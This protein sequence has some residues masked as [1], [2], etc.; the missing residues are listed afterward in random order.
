MVP[1]P[2]R[3]E[4]VK[5]PEDNKRGEEV[6]PLPT[7][8][9]RELLRGV[10]MSTCLSGAAKH[11]ADNDAGRNAQLKEDYGLSRQASRLDHFLSH[12]WRTSRWKKYL[13]MLVMFNLLPAA[14][15]SSIVS[16]I[17]AIIACFTVGKHQLWTASFG[18]VTFLITLFQWQWM[19]EYF[20]KPT[21]VFLDK[22]CIAQHD[23]SLK[24]KGISGLASF[25][26]NSQSLT[27]FW[28]QRYFTRLW[29]TYE[30][31]T[32]FKDDQ[33][34]RL[35]LMPVA[36]SVQIL[37]QAAMAHPLTW[38]YKILVFLI[39][40]VFSHLETIIIVSSVLL[41][42]FTVLATLQ[43]YVTIGLLDDI[44]ALPQQLSNFSITASECY[45][46]SVHHVHPET[47]DEIPCDRRVVFRTL[48]D[49]YGTEDKEDHLA[50]FDH[51]VKTRLKSIVL[52]Q[53]GGGALPLRYSLPVVLSATMPLLPLYLPEWA[54]GQPEYIDLHQFTFQIRELVEFFK[55]GLLVMLVSSLGTHA[56]Y[57]G[58]R[59]KP[60]LS[61]L[62]AAMLLA[63]A[64][65]FS[66]LIF[67]L[68]IEVAFLL[69]LK[70]SLMVLIPFS[71]NLL[72][73]LLLLFPPACCCCK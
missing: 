50:A 9:D 41:P 20:M 33:K 16:L 51:L 69:T 43:I 73:C 49:W 36:L 1:R 11:W 4:T 14:I 62:K 47:G 46:C 5:I 67:Q 58:F 3:P 45:C 30:I 61:R 34:K 17:V 53:L 26:L 68:P 57:I 64:V 22:L 39:W 56:S 55:A 32:Y 23:P 28:S 2:K 65:T 12:D 35:Q 19:R 42:I 37:L 44:A 13:S 25:L 15:V 71:V 18:Y 66:S 40:D 24:E 60:Y 7:T 27:I 52:K 8:L 72:I 59:L 48:Q 6:Q 29:C 70:N 31:A 63:P 54:E 21:F 38:C 10:S